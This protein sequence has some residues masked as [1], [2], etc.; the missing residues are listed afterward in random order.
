MNL[1]ACQRAAGLPRTRGTIIVEPEMPEHAR[2]AT[3]EWGLHHVCLPRKHKA[4]TSTTP[5]NGCTQRQRVMQTALL[6][7]SCAALQVINAV[8]ITAS[9]P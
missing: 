7:V 9:V 5:A 2:Q 8:C 6:P 1:A 3:V 4:Q